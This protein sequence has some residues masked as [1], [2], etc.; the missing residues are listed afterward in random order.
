MLALSSLLFTASQFYRV[1]NA[2]VA[3]DL[4]HDLHLSSEALGGI[5]AAF[6]YGFAAA[7]VPLALVLDR[8]G[9]RWT[10]T[11]LTL[12][13]SAGAVVFANADGLAGA[14]AGR[15]LLGV[16]MAGNLMGSLKL[17]G[18]WFS[19]REFATLAGVIATLGT[20]GNILATTPLALLVSAVGWRRAFVFVAVATT[21]ASVAF[22]VVVRDR[23]QH[24]GTGKGPEPSGEISSM[25]LL[26][27][28]DYWLISF[29]AFCRYGAFLA[30]QGLWAGPYLVTV[31]GLSS[32][33]AANFILLMNVAGVVG[34]PIGGWLSDRVLRSRKQVMM[35]SLAGIAGAQLG[36]A[37]APERASLWIVGAVMVLLGMTSSFG[38]VVYAHMKDLMPAR[39]SGM[40]MTGVNFFTMLGAG[41]FLHGIGWI[42]DHWTAGAHGSGG[43]RAGFGLGAA[44]TGLALVLYARTRDAH[45]ARE[46]VG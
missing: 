29:G 30:I 16:G 1:A 11:V 26:K 5:S 3:S 4:Q 20:L 13:G 24:G 2:V 25:V 33:S 27:S 42:V 38:Q 17:V 37:L 40:A 22:W 32:V 19:P 44:A 41:T 43:Y 45:V 6:F 34:G 7:Q 23:E 8:I 9:A 35:I 31:V 28:R 46:R 36:L 12:V 21:I 14:T 10:M 15:V 18:D 39:M